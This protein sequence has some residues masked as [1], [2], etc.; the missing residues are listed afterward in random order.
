MAAA[1][2]LGRAP[3][4]EGHPAWT[5]LSA[6]PVKL[7]ASIPMRAFRVRDLLALASGQTIE[8]EWQIT[9]DVPLKTG[10]VQLCWCEFEV[11]EQKISLRITRLA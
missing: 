6:L 4:I 1:L 3:E 9:E 10:E 5:T 8:S 11:V 7:Q 2:P